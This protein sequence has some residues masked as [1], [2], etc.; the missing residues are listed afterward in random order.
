[1]STSG[2]EVVGSGHRDLET[3]FEPFSKVEVSN[4]S[5]K[6][7]FYRKNQKALYTIFMVNSKSTESITLGNNENT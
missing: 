1:M 2:Q 7:G 4:L 6:N 5:L 3:G